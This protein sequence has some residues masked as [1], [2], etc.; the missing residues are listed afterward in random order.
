M[1]SAFL[2][3]QLTIVTSYPLLAARLR[4]ERKALFN[5]S[6]PKSI[7]DFRNMCKPSVF[8]RFVFY[9]FRSFLLTWTFGHQTFGT[10]YKR[11]IDCK[12]KQIGL[13]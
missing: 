1:T 8:A 7:Q 12:A 9:F 5:G 4:E 2:K 11:Q 13:D 3:A 10:S 6:R